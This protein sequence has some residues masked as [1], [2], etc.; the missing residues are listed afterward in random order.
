MESVEQPP[1]EPSQP[2]AEKKRKRTR[3]PDKRT[4]RPDKR[5]IPIVEALKNPSPDYI[6]LRKDIA[7]TFMG[8]GVP[9]SK[10][11]MNPSG[12][13]LS[14]GAY[15]M[16]ARA[17]LQFSKEET[18]IKCR[19]STSTYH[20]WETEER[21]PNVQELARLCR[22]LAVPHSEIHRIYFVAKTAEIGRE[23]GLKPRDMGDLCIE[24]VIG[25][26][27]RKWTRYKRR[28]K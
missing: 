6:S 17:R 2:T 21:F 20:S 3:S 25:Y 4:S 24:A 16:L 19:V 23:L 15:L 9:E 5:A 22:V 11:M 7:V 26:T 13:P 18:A 14:F 12:H 8:R 28:S 10:T 27:H 1:S